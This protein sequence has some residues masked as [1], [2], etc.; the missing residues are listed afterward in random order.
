LIKNARW[1]IITSNEVKEI[2][3]YTNKL[4]LQDS[5]IM[6]FYNNTKKEQSAKDS[7]S[8]AAP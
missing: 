4:V 6:N 5:V 2:S 8:L 1:A 7:S 3:D